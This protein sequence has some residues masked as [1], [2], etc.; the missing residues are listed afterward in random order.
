MAFCIQL[1]VTPDM[2]ALQLQLHVFV[3]SENFK[4]LQG[5]GSAINLADWYRQPG[6]TILQ[7][8]SVCGSEEV[9]LVDS[10]ARVRVLSFVTRQF[11]FVSRYLNFAIVPQRRLV[12]RHPLNFKRSQTPYTLHQMAPACL[13]FILTTPDRR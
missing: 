13:F 12:D 7:M 9:A 11:R 2:R 5:Q 3:F 1:A 10:S 4:T 6:I 8:T